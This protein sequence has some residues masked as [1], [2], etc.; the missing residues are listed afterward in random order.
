MNPWDQFVNI[1]EVT[2]RA[3][4]QVFAS[5]GGHKW[6]AAIIALTLIVRTLLLPLVV[7]QI[8]TSQ[9]MQRLKPEM[10]RL[11]QK[12][13]KDRARM[14]QEQQELFRR[15]NVSPAGCLGPMIAQ[16]PVM[17]AMYYAIRNLSDSVKEMPFLGLGSLTD[18]AGASAA[19]WLLLAIMTVAQIV[20]TKQLSTGQDAQQQRMMIY[21]MPLFFLFIMVRLPAGLVLYWATSQVYQ[22]V[23]QVIMLRGTP[24]PPPQMATVRPSN[25]PPKKPSANG[26]KKN[27][28]AKRRVR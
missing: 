21:M 28:N 7:K 19:G 27:Q 10:D 16:A 8:R 2:L 6:A 22:L 26:K 3:L 4:T 9:K 12:F 1:F 13:G 23:Q 20:T 11:Q 25:N 18:N 24:P 5:F 17:T 14:A 15:E